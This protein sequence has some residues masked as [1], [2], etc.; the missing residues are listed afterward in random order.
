MAMIETPELIKLLR[1]FAQRI[2]LRGGNPYRANAYARAAERLGTLTMPLDHGR[3]LELGCMM[4]INPDAHSTDELALM[5][6]GVELARKG[7]VPA[8]RV[9]NSLTLPRPMQHLKRR[10]SVAARAA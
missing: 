1:E 3:A 7:G 9:L 5:H 8:K 6:W 4:S 2:A 10:K